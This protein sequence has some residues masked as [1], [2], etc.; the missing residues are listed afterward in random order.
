VA[1]AAAAAAMLA[2]LLAAWD[3]PRSAAAPSKASAA[4]YALVHGCYALRSVP[5]GKLVAKSGSG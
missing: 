3:A 1:A 4:R 5:S 2:L